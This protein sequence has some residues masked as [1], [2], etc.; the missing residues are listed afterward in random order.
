[1]SMEDD[2][3]SVHHGR[4]DVVLEVEHEEDAEDYQEHWNKPSSPFCDL[5]YEEVIT[6][7]TQITFLNEVFLDKT[8]C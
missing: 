3:Q 7:H 4:V 6:L 1:M 2:I 8:Y 5:E